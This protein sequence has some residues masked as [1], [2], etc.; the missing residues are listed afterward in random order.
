[1]KKS[2]PEFYS[3]CLML[4][5]DG[6]SLGLISPILP[7]LFMNNILG[8]NTEGYFLSKEMLYSL[9]SA[10]FLLLS[11]VG[12]PMLGALSDSYGR[13][14]VIVY[15]IFVLVIS[16]ILS[17]IAIMLG[18]M[19]LFFFSIALSGFLTGTYSVCYAYIS[20]ISGS[21]EKMLSNLR[22]PNIAATLGFIIGPGLSVLTS[23]IKINNP[24]VVPYIIAVILGIINFFLLSLSKFNEFHV[25]S[26]DIKKTEFKK[27]S[28]TPNKLIFVLLNSL[29][30]SVLLSLY[31][32]TSKRSRY[33][34]FTYLL[35][36]FALG[37]FLQSLPL[38]LSYYYLYSPDQIGKFFV[39]MFIIM[40][41]SMFFLQ[42][43]ITPYINYE[44]QL[45]L[46]LMSIS[47]LLTISIAL[48]FISHD[49]YKLKVISLTWIVAIIFYML[50]PF[51]T[52]GFTNLFANNLKFAG[53]GKAMGGVGQINSI[54]FFISSLLV[55]YIMTR[56]YILILAIASISFTV[57]YNMLKKIMTR[58]FTKND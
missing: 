28:N 29:R 12:M 33:L 20:D 6:I 42:K 8:F 10:L 9:S 56:N 14:K 40:S 13:R 46:A 31:I 51:V 43:M 53:Q 18:N 27:N 39:M 57:S 34:A 41:I 22:L 16:D 30:K 26:K 25:I 3:I 24:L 55:G 50:M 49:I 48:E 52:L 37:L 54:G 44:K 35:F 15:S 21:S 36:Q 7:E 38:R 17:I 4:F 1:M 2:N 32:F 5:I 45:K 47:L 19:F 58:H 23:Y 11:I